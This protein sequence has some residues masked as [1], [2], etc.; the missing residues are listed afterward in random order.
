MN[1]GLNECMH[2]ALVHT[3]VHETTMDSTLNQIREDIF[4]SH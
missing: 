1:E 3:G 4:H 2:Y